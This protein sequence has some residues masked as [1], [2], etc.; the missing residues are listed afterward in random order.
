MTP[1][2]RVIHSLPGRKRL[3]IDEKRGDEAYFMALEKELA[4]CPD[5]LTV[6]ATPVTGTVLVHHRADDPDFLRYPIERELFHLDQNFPNQNLP[7]SHSLTPAAQVSTHPKTAKRETNPGSSSGL[8]L[9]F[10]I[11]LGMTGMGIVQAIE[12]NIAIPAVAAFWYALSI[13]PG[14]NIDN[15]EHPSEGGLEES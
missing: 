8:N 12:G 15:P 6:E 3:K 9:R 5:I 1:F 10:L 13:L 7:A 2:A 4:E 14:T 11:F